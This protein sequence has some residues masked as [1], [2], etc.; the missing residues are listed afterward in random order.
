M[1]T[2][3]RSSFFIFFPFQIIVE[4]L[5]E[6]LGKYRNVREVFLYDKNPSV[7]RE[8]ASQMQAVFGDKCFTLPV[9]NIASNKGNNFYHYP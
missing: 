9:E 3:V 5:E 2:H 4:T 1:S 7:V 8:F 6:I